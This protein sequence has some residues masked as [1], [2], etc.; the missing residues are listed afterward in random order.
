MNDQV[1]LTIVSLAVGAIGVVLWYFLRRVIEMPSNYATKQELRDA[2]NGWKNEIYQLR[3]DH[4][5]DSRDNK[6][7]LDKIAGDVTGI[8]KRIDRI[9]ELM[10]PK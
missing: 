9:F 3:E 4:R 5:Q 10:Q 2:T 8:H 6:D 1:W 7:T